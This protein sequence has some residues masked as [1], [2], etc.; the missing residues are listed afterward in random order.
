[1]MREGY[2]CSLK[3]LVRGFWLLK[4]GSLGSDT[5]KRLEKYIFLHQ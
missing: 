3:C 4:V 1:M 2:I 5:F